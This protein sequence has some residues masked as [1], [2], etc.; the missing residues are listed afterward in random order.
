M[1]NTLEQTFTKPQQ[2]TTVTLKQ[3]IGYY[4]QQQSKISGIERD[5][6]SLRS[7]DKHQR[8]WEEY[9]AEDTRVGVQ[10]LYSS[11]KELRQELETLQEFT[12]TILSDEEIEEQNHKVQV[13]R[14]I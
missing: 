8:N 2:G 14:D 9:I 6:G 13:A 5:L 4:N 7:G 11:L 12:V 1:K 10:I 3:I